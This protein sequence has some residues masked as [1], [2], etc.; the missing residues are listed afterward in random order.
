MQT[1]QRLHGARPRARRVAFPPGIWTTTMAD[2]PALLASLNPAT[3]KDAENTLTQFANQPG[4]LQ[5]LLQ[6]VLATGAD[7]PVRLAG[8]VYLKNT[9]KRK[10]NEV[11]LLS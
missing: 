2:L 9:V 7:R 3:R 6:L 11:V 5:A 4:F 1:P 8:S 10:W